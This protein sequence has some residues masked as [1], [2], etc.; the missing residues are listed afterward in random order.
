M[1]DNDIFYI[2]LS[3]NKMSNEPEPLS[4]RINRPGEIIRAI[5]SPSRDIK[6]QGFYNGGRSQDIPAT[7]IIA[8]KNN[9]R[10][11]VRSLGNIRYNTDNSCVEVIQYN[12]TT[13]KDEWMNLIT[14]ASD[15]ITDTTA[16]SSVNTICFI[17]EN[18]NNE[19]LLKISSTSIDDIKG[20]Y[21]LT[22]SH[23]GSPKVI[24]KIE[25]DFPSDD[26]LKHNQEVIPNSLDLIEK[27]KPYK[28]QKIG[29]MY[30]ASYNGIVHDKWLWEI[31]LIAQDVSTIPYLNFMV[32][33]MP[34]DGMYMLSYLNLIGLLVQGSK[35]LYSENKSL[36][37]DI[38]T[39][40]KDTR[41]VSGSAVVTIQQLNNKIEDLKSRIL[42]LKK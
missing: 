13:N 29:K 41:D 35:D 10:Y 30:D 16:D 1:N 2:T 37:K 38:E 4:V 17:T 20:S 15:S 21:G 3:Y 33:Q 23:G 5:K 11:G 18:D 9:T 24:F 34:T 6:Y 12:P 42:A 8:G 36:K 22:L 7:K 31:G 39:C 40:K 14:T 28:Y 25:I 26:R 19:K 32:N 27:L